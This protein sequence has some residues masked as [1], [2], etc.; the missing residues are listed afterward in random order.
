LA[1]VFGV[2]RYAIGECDRRTAMRGCVFRQR[3]FLQ[4]NA[5]S[6]RE[7]SDEMECIIQYASF[8]RCR[9]PQSDERLRNVTNQLVAKTPTSR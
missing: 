9:L 8:T 6:T 2:A 3:T 7:Q 4:C 5:R 1:G